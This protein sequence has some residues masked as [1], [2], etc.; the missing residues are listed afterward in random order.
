MRSRIVDK[1]LLILG[2]SIFGVLGTVHLL[3]TFF[4]NKFDAYDSS[5]TKAMKGT[6][7]ILTKET[8]VW[9]AWVGFNASHSLGAMLV[10]GFYIPLTVSYFHIIQQSIWFS[11]LPVII[12]FSY[13]L[14]AKKYWFRIPFVGVLV[15][16]MC[17]VGAAVLINT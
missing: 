13:L 2:A 5:V 17:F 11:V 10:A 15:S 3:Y 1:I 14:L 9:D 16:T 12:G 6:S 4:T 7:P 8:S